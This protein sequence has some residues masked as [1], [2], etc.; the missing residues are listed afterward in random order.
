VRHLAPSFSIVEEIY[1]HKDISRNQVR[2]LMTL[3]TSSVDLGVTG[4][5]RKDND[6]PLAW[7]RPYGEGRVFYSALGHF[8]HTW[9]DE[10]FQIHILNA[11]LWLT[12]Q[13]D[14]ASEPRP[15]AQP[16]IWADAVGNSATMLPPGVI[17]PGSLVSIYGENLTPGSSLAAR[18][19]QPAQKLAGTTVRMNGQVIP[20]LYASPGQINAVAPFGLGGAPCSRTGGQCAQIDVVLPGTAAASALT[21]ISERTP[22][23][24]AVTRD[25]NS[26][27][28]W[29]TGLGG[30]R[31]S[32]ELFETVWRPRVIVNG[33]EA[34]LLF[35]GL[36]PGWTGLYQ[37]NVLVPPGLLAEPR[38]EWRLVE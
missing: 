29:A 35:S 28:L 38:L 5:N 15:P 36:A 22:G 4:V 27:T 21:A 2:V 37:V 33:T 10:R 8:D 14:G 26:A 12:Q 18:E 16:L 6:F 13:V 30:V 32:R 19:G 20:I 1:Q 23:V 17:S 3:D 7:V 34:P 25:G 31:A 9:R 11:L 24:F